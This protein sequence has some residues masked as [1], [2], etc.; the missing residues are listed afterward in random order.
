MPDFQK[1]LKEK[2]ESQTYASRNTGKTRLGALFL[3][4][5]L[6]LCSLPAPA[7]S[8]GDEAML[9]DIVHFQSIA[10]HYAGSDGQPVGNVVSDHALLEQGTPLVLYYTY[11]IPDGKIPEIKANTNYYLDVS[12]HLVLS[13]SDSGSPLTMETDD[14][15]RQ[16]GT[17]YANGTRAF[18]TFLENDDGSGTVLSDYGELHNAYFY[19]DVRRA[20]APPAQELPVEGKT[21]L[22]AIK[23]ENGEQLRF[24]YAENEPVTSQAKIEKNGSL[25]DKTITWTVAYTPW[26]NPSGDEGITNDTLFELRDFIDAGLHQYVD[27]SAK[28]DGV[29]IPSYPSR[30]QINP[31]L[32]TYVLLE[33]SADGD[34]SQ[35][36]FGGT[37][38]R[39]GTATLGNP[40]KPL[41]LTYETTIK[42]E[43]LLPGGKEGQAVTNKAELFAGTD[44]A[45]H[46][47]NI[48]D[49]CTVPL[50][51]PV[52]LSKT[53]KTTRYTDG[54]G[55]VTD[56]T[57]SFFPNGFT[58]TGDQALT[59]HDKLPAGST[60]V[61][62]S[63]KVNGT[64]AGADTDDGGFTI[65]PIE[66]INQPVTVTYQTRAPEE[67]YDSGTSLGSNIAWFSFQYQQEDYTTPKAVTPV[68]SGNGGGAGTAPLE[69]SN[70]GYRSNDRTI[71]WTVTINPHKANFK[72]GTFTDDLGSV[73]PACGVDGH[74][75][76]LELFGGKD[77]ITVLLDGSPLTDS[78]LVDLSYQDQVLTVTVGNIGA[79]TVTLQY[80]TKVCDPCIFANNTVKVPFTNSVST[81]NMMIGATGV[82][83]SAK[84]AS[85]ANISSAL[86]SKK[87]PVYDYASQTFRWTIEIDG[88]GL[89]LTDAILTDTL[90]AGL[91]YV[92]GSLHTVPDIPDA[93]ARTS[94]Q[95]LTI[96]LGTL[97][98]KTDVTFDTS[99]DPEA[100][101]FCSDEAVTI[102]NTARLNGKADRVLF[103]EV[104]HGVTKRFSNHGLVKSSNV[105]NQQEYIQ[106]E[107]LINPFGL[108]LPEQPSLVDTLDQRLQLDYDTLYFC[109]ASLTGTSS[110]PNQKPGYVK[111]GEEKPLSLSAYDPETNSFTVP[112]PIEAG[113]KSAYVLSYRADIIERQAG[114]YGN[115]VRFEGGLV[116]L[117]GNKNNSA[118]VGGGGGGGGGGVAA[119]KA[120]ITIT[121]TDRDTQN[122]LAGVTFT[123][124]Q[125]DSAS[126]A[127]G[128]PFA[129]GTTNAQGKI[130]FKVKPN[131]LYELVETESLSGYDSRFHWIRLPSGVSETK[132]G[133][134]LTAEAARTELNLDLTN[135]LIPETWAATVTKI[136]ESEAAPLAN[137]V[138]G[139]YAEKACLTLLKT[140]YN[141]TEIDTK[142]RG[143]GGLNLLISSLF[144]FDRLAGLVFLLVCRRRWFALGA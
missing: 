75:R 33:P 36:S 29:P 108:S 9:S 64:S 89:P 37:K 94:G 58:F 6:L 7:A 120:G 95:D 86:L 39:A 100:L 96:Q 106:Y 123:L 128:L 83:R 76:G 118:S 32:E 122:P 21:N 1:S 110:N 144:Q 73:G 57:V 27:G 136:S 126:K 98:E 124:Y 20:D 142:D 14:G 127:R 19:L 12:P 2:N 125:W 3:C 116:L 99:A 24:G 81:D 60:L 62:D 42:D 79:R 18:I 113:S 51:K 54:T 50:P 13:H 135:S 34:T 31:E 103:S 117:G 102:T 130:S 112:L 85:T 5:I 88:A 82:E 17:I 16:F 59:L 115:S 44:G 43:L 109:K 68:D 141:N 143:K 77:D 90:P 35:L 101:G 139:L 72:S 30:E 91:T 84:A 87:A 119:R 140:G 71:S 65:S 80:T 47:L 137:A 46:S 8:A 111:T 92:D 67:M 134:L 121:K 78:S 69:K 93:A 61:T 25:T 41:V 11:E 55:S 52:W 53:G 56:W 48:K 138:F 66:T 49:A 22:Y 10:L 38:F 131:A 70:G 4:L 15:P 105:N 107:V 114:G 40:A 97:T 26:Q 45:F 23:F 63:V 133:L 104:S 132:D 74:A 28:V 129:Q